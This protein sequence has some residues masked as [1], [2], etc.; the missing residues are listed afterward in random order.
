MYYLSAYLLSYLVCT[1][2]IF[3]ERLQ[4][5]VINCKLTKS[6]I[7]PLFREFIWVGIMWYLDGTSKSGTCLW[8]LRVTTNI[9]ETSFKEVSGLLTGENCLKGRKLFKLNHRHRFGE[10]S[11][12]SL[13]A[14]NTKSLENS[15]EFWKYIK[16]KF[17]FGKL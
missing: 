12:V 3:P 2:L 15:E 8:I 6:P 4:L 13:F 17:K 10:N 5:S 16:I 9:S 7:I 11:V 1:R 14:L